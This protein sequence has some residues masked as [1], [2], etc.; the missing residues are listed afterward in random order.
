VI[1]SCY[2]S[3]QS[4]ILTSSSSAI[5]VPR[6]CH[7]RSQ[8][9]KGRGPAALCVRTI[10][11][12][13][14]S[15]SGFQIVS[16]LACRK[17]TPKKHLHPLLFTAIAKT[18]PEELVESPK[19][20]SAC[21]EQW[22]WGL[23]QL[24]RYQMLQDSIFDIWTSQGHSS[25]GSCDPVRAIRPASTRFFSAAPKFRILIYR[26]RLGLICSD[27][28]RF[29]LLAPALWLFHSCSAITV[30]TPI[31]LLQPLAVS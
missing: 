20:K 23:I 6:V 11:E 7:R 25:A 2:D 18:Q 13:A 5:L 27:T 3:L 29:N 8:T 12:L 17:V 15:K 24:L 4:P 19:G 14:L 26:R 28:H 22:K 31:P 21:A 9:I 30:P 1:G 16:R 10:A